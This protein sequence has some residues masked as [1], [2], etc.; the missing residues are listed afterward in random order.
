MNP[1]ESGKPLGT[2]TESNSKSSIDWI[3]KRKKIFKGKCAPTGKLF[4]VIEVKSKKYGK[5]SGYM[6]INGN[7]GDDA[8][9]DVQKYLRDQIR[10]KYEI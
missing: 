1:N 6:L 3:S 2:G 9:M 10:A 8:E 4:I 7:C 5:I